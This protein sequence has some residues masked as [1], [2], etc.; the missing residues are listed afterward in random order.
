MWRSRLA[1]ALVLAFFANTTCTYVLFAWLP[2]SWP[3]PAWEPSVGGRW[4]AVFAIL[5]LPASIFSPVLTARMRNPFP[6]VVGFAACWVGGLL[7]L[8]LSPAHG[9]A[10]WMVLLGIGPGTFPIMLALIGLRS[11]TPAIA[12]ALSGMVQGLGYGLAVVGPWHRSAARGDGW[13]AR[14]VPRAASPWSGSCS[15]AAGSPAGRR[16]WALIPG[17]TLGPSPLHKRSA[18]ARIPFSG[19]SR[20]ALRGPPGRPR[21]RR[22]RRH[23]RPRPR[24]DPRDRAPRA[25]PAAR[26]RRLGDQ[27]GDAAGQ[28]GRHQPARVRRGA[29]AP[30]RRRPPGV[31][32]RRGRRS[33][34]PQHPARRGRGR[35]AARSV[36]EQ[37]AEY[38]QNETLAGVSLNLE[39]V[40]ANPTVRCT[41][42]ACAGRPSATASRACCRRPARRRPRVLLQRPRRA[43]RP[44]LPLAAGPRAGPAG[45]RG[46]LRRQVHHRDRRAGGGRRPRRRRARPAHAGATRPT[47]RSARAAST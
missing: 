40:S 9:T 13:L 21:A 25:T 15:S 43:D 32:T 19:D 22:R 23:V 38:G 33:R 2:T 20:P 1:W 12:V 41:S 39:F 27:R 10:V 11:R 17:P 18:R 47:R 46:R 37:G 8:M 36:V 16:C 4:L 35:R 7:G 5:G 29:R 30:P 14:A 44:L 26:A 24:R 28:E 42:A 34:L 45:A 31:A 6:L 3:T